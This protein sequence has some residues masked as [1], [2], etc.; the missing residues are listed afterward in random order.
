MNSKQQYELEILRSKWNWDSALGV[1]DRVSFILDK[2]RKDYVKVVGSETVGIGLARYQSECLAEFG[3]G[4]FDEVVEN[5][6]SVV[7]E[8]A[9]EAVQEVF[10]G[11]PA[12][13]VT[14]FLGETVAEN[15]VSKVSGTET[16]TDVEPVSSG[17]GSD[18]ASEVPA[19]FL[20]RTLV[21]LGGVAGAGVLLVGVGLGNVAPELAF[22]EE[23]EYGVGAQTVFI[24]ASAPSL[25]ALR[26]T[27][28][29][30][31]NP[32]V[33]RAASS[34]G[35]NVRAISV[36]G[37]GNSGL[38]GSAL[39]YV[40]VNGWDC[41]L[42]VEQALRDMGHSVGDIGPMNFGGYGTV[43]ND[44]ASVQPGDIMMRG[45]HVA[46][47]AGNGMAVHGGFNG[48]VVYTDGN[49]SNPYSYG[50]FVRVG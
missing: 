9:I 49:I 33:A 37:A 5:V 31:Y 26:D 2:S 20:K 8:D 42:L 24:G 40:G 50:T 21:R 12:D 47:Y 38:L 43:F 14:S 18:S 45:G 27:V 41:T 48:R 23:S 22:A 30:S 29:V 17:S 11:Y 4:T 28:S 35:G 1:E 46:I 7:L 15:I 16:G 10:E 44:P 39:K 19:S 13:T 36:S 3:V 6:K 25:S 32:P 34:L